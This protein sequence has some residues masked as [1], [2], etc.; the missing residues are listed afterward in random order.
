MQGLKELLTRGQCS[1]STQQHWHNTLLC[2]VA[3]Q[4]PKLGGEV[5][6]ISLLPL[7]VS[8][9]WATT[10]GRVH[11]S[12]PTDKRIAAFWEQIFPAFILPLTVIMAEAARQQRN[13]KDNLSHAEIVALIQA[14]GQI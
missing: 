6:P 14:Y 4:A 1:Q 13:R 8:P 3:W 10:W 11:N 7:E 5:T 9:R 2:L 12:H